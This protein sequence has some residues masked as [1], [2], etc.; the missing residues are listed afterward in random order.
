MDM[1]NVSN[2]V[3]PEG[4]VN[5]IHDKDHKLIWGRL[6]YDT[7]YAGDTLQQTYSG[8]N[9]WNPDVYYSNND[10]YTP[11]VGITIPNTLNP[12]VTSSFTDSQITVIST[13]KNGGG[14]Y[15]SPALSPGTYH[16]SVNVTPSGGSGAR[17]RAN[18]LDSSHTVLRNDDYWSI[19]AGTTR[20]IDFNV[21]VA[22][23]EVYI[24]ISLI[25]TGDNGGTVT[26]NNPQLELGSSATTYQ[27]FVGGIPSPNPDYPQDVNVVTGEQT[28]TVSGKNL[29][30]KS[31][32]NAVSTGATWD[33]EVVTS[34]NFSNASNVNTQIYWPSDKVIPIEKP[35]IV[36]MEI[37][38][39]SGSTGTF[40][41]IGDG[42]SGAFVAVEH[43]T[44]TTQWQR[45]S[46]KLT[47]PEGFILRAL[48]VR[49]S[50]INGQIQIRNIQVEFGQ[51][52]SEYEPYN[53]A[54]YT[55]NLGSTELCKIGDHQDYIYKSGD[56]WYVHK[57][58]GKIELDGSNDETWSIVG[59]G[60][61][62]FFY[63]Y[64]SIPNYLY[65]GLAQGF[66]C[67]AGVGASIGST[68][69]ANGVSIT[70]VAEFRVRYGTEMTLANWKSYL[71]S[72]PMSVYYRLATPTDTKITDATLVGQLD[73][74]HQF[75]TRYGYSATVSGNL[76]LIIDKTNL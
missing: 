31:N 27:K 62:N 2:L 63:A 42:Y 54:N 35:F 74:I 38:L 71:S 66:I 43:P 7:K 64:N 47:P 14:M 9:L 26:A 22:S 65:T 72:T 33:G 44:I 76:P 68:T 46:Y 61:V 19:G 49:M 25:A 55:I 52:A 75:L 11:S 8:K 18:I 30:N 28:V 32:I 15:L 53:G 58:C 50:Q 20:Q 36:S 23:G 34:K 67:S 45:Y 51:N 1:Q 24:A 29:F 5:T 16:I 73:A 70:N 3:I 37:R 6:A 41:R 69:T 17:I 4:N 48:L 60:T 56:D 10:V 21:T 13:I 57:D 40:A 39:T 59:S 12:N